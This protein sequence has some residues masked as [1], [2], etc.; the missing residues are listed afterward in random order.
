VQW[1]ITHGRLYGDSGGDNNDGAVTAVV[2]A[3]S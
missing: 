1:A 2:G 3:T